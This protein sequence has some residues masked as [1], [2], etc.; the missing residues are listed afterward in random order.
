[1]NGRSD[2]KGPANPPAPIPSLRD[3][4]KQRKAVVGA[5]VRSAITDIL[6]RGGSVS[7]KQLRKWGPDGTEYFFRRLRERINSEMQPSQPVAPPKQEAVA[8]RPVALPV[9]PAA[10]QENAPVST[11]RDWAEQQYRPW[12]V[13][14]RAFLQGLIAATLFFVGTAVLIR[15]SPELAVHI[16]QQLQDWR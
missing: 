10:K 5:Q 7:E 1:M 3:L 11:E 6:T 16:Q 13:R 4:E 15:L 2:K 8:A 12:S 14:T 9:A